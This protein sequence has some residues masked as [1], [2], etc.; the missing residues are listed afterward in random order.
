M[1][2]TLNLTPETET[3][4]IAQA[5][6]RGMS[7]EELLKAAI[8][9]LLAA[10]EPTLPTVISSQERAE[11]FI[12]WARSYSIKTPLLSDEAISRE[13]IYRERSDGPAYQK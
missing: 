7:V 3:R 2:I 1:T 9:T 8:D 12:N 10:S 11:K 6:A 13:S 5:A 4:L